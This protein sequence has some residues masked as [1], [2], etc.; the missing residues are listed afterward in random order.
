MAWSEFNMT[1]RMYGSK[2]TIE[3]SW[4]YM[5]WT[6]LY[7]LIHWCLCKW[8]DR[9][10]YYYCARYRPLGSDCRCC[11]PRAMICC[12]QVCDLWAIFWWNVSNNAWNSLYAWPVNNSTK[13]KIYNFWPDTSDIGQTQTIYSWSAVNRQWSMQIKDTICELVW[14]DI[15][16]PCSCK[17][18]TP[19]MYYYCTDDWRWGEE[20]YTW[21]MSCYWHLTPVLWINS[22]GN[23]SIWPIRQSWAWEV[24]HN[25]SW[26][27]TFRVCWEF[28]A[29]KDWLYVVNNP[30]WNC[31]LSF[32][33]SDMEEIGGLHS[34]FYCYA[35]NCCW[36]DIACCKN[37]F[38]VTIWTSGSETLAFSIHNYGKDI[39]CNRL[40]LHVPS[41]YICNPSTNIEADNILLTLYAIDDVTSINR[42]SSN[43]RCHHEDINEFQ[44]HNNPQCNYTDTEYQCISDMSILQPRWSSQWAEYV[45]LTY[46][47]QDDFICQLG[48]YPKVL[49]WFLFWVNNP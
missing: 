37:Y 45:R 16:N 30:S 35:L 6:Q 32:E 40:D 12:W 47:I 10:C 38:P 49:Y 21:F 28:W 26:L 42:L 15:T 36:I 19:L 48:Y 4:T 8:D 25:K 1:S 18:V 33:W 7:D 5:S 29:N 46:Y 9:D 14:W 23:V 13:F 17:P 34:C 3:N 44:D 31:M 24:T 39:C 20:W 22:W 2:C 27:S 11:C 41:S 43:V